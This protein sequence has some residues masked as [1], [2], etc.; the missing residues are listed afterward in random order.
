MDIIEWN[1]PYKI[2]IHG[3]KM[4]H[5]FG[6]KIYVIK[7]LIITLHDVEKSQTLTTLGMLNQ[8]IFVI[9]FVHVN[10]I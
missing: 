10:T 8:P 1:S 4:Q 5:E 2:K 6:I 9:I 3:V 7:L